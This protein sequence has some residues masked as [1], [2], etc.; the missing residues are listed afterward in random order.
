MN[1]VK[2]AYLRHGPYPA[3]IGS[4]VPTKK[5]LPARGFYPRQGFALVE[6]RASGEQLYRVTRDNCPLLDCRHIAVEES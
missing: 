3:L 5:N 4:F 2:S 6:V 1:R